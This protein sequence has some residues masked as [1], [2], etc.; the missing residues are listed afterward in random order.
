MVSLAARIQ[1]CGPV[2]DVKA[3]ERAAESLREVAGNAWPALAPVF[4]ASPY[5]S[6]IARRWPERLAETL[7]SDPD[8]RVALLIAETSAAGDAADLEAGARA[9]REAK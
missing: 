6:A 4:A 2:V 3:A 5:L 1:P 8:V 9:M 7:A